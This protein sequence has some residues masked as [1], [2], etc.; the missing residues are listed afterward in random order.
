MIW[1]EEL[2]QWSQRMD[3]DKMVCP[4]NLNRQMEDN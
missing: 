4:H 3:I 1:K 2:K